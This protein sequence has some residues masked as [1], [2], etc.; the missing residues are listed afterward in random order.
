[1]CI[2]RLESLLD[3][4]ILRKKEIKGF[5]SSQNDKVFYQKKFFLGRFGE[6]REFGNLGN[7]DLGNPDIVEATFCQKPA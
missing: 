4:G 6:I 2:C 7:S 5:Y 1:M 3:F